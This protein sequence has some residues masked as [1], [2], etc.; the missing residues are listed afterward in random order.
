MTLVCLFISYLF[1]FEFNADKAFCLT[2]CTGCG[3]WHRLK[4]LHQV[5]PI[6]LEHDDCF[7]K[8]DSPKDLDIFK[9]PVSK[10]PTNALTEGVIPMSNRV[11]Y[12]IMVPLHPK[13]TK[14]Y[15]FIQS[16]AL[17]LPLIMLKMTNFPHYR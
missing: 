1:W 12:Q 16:I 17:T 3:P 2:H 10:K 11:Y 8:C 9:G 4:F 13:Y 7:V 5:Y 6:L 15:L 14:W